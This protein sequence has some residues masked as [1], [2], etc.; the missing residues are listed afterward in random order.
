MNTRKLNFKTSYIIVGVVFLILLI[1]FGN[2][3]FLIIDAGERGVIFRP[4]TSGL[5][6]DNIYGEGF[7]VVAPWNRMY[8]YNVREQQRE[9]TMDVLDKSGLK[10]NVDVT[11]R[12]NPSFNEIPSLHER[13]GPDYVNVLVV[14]EVRSSVRQVS[15]RYTAEEI[16]STKRQQVEGAIIEETRKTL[17]DNFIEMRALLIRSIDLPAQIKTAIESKLTQEQEALAYEF[18]LNKE[19]SE[20]ER[21]R[22]E[23]QGI[24]DY[25]KII[26]ASL[27]ENILKQKGIDAT[28]DLAKSAN[29]KVVVVGSGK[30]GLPLILGGN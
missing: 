25:N 19:K 29:T 3:M 23:A 27:T 1:I 4:Y 18:R 26:S 15:G 22:I 8:V 6:R 9:E 11:V 14:P 20:A 21:R 28:L 2:R 5:D 7:H 13:F 10:I 30:E 16:Y 12:F 17:G 24:S